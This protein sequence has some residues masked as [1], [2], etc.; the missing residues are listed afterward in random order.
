M[1]REEAEQ[2]RREILN[3]T[4]KILAEL[5]ADLRTLPDPRDQSPSQPEQCQPDIMGEGCDLLRAA[6]VCP[7]EANSQE[8][9]SQK[10]R[11]GGTGAH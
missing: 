3:R 6:V 7:S 2:E 4:D 5:T 9:E 11:R 1:R 10:A 8:D